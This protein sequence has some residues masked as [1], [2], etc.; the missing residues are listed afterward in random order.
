MINLIHLKN[1][2]CFNDISLSLANLNIFTGLNGMGK[3][4]VIQSI[5]LLKQSL[6]F[7]GKPGFHFSGNYTDLGLSQDVQYDKA[8]DEEI[9][10]ELMVNNQK[11]CFNSLFQQ[12]KSFLSFEE[13]K[14][15][16]SLN[17]GHFRYLNANRIIPQKQYSI[18]D[19]AEKTFGNNGE[20]AIQFFNDNSNREIDNKD[21]IVP[22]EKGSSLGNQTRL[23]LDKIVPG[24]MPEITVDLQKQT[25][26]LSFS[27]IEGINKTAAFKNINVGFGLTYVL[28]VIITLL[29][30]NKGDIVI[31][32]NPE[33][34]IH[35]AGQ[36]VL[37]ELLARVSASGVQIFVETHSDHII[38]GVRIAVKKGIIPSENVFTGFFYK[39]EDDDYKHKCKSIKLLKNGKTSEWPRGFFDEWD[40]ALMELL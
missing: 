31:I 6:E 12:D 11:F 4:T 20:F 32:E 18:T 38:N 23:W 7:E 3:S 35:P 34:H 9:T 27:F 22:D 29:S 21:I 25:S 8:S 19:D 1:F 37:G 33:A 16:S 2:K 40:E 24:A 13:I 15:E 28:P 17:F 36:R 14:S 39:D 26:Y 30:S 10:I 5:L